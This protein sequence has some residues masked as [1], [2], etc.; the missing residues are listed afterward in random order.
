MNKI[1]L[2][3]IVLFCAVACAPKEKEVIPEP[4]LTKVQL[5]T[6]YGDIILQLYNETPQHRDNFTKHVNNGVYDSVQYHRVIENFMIQAGNPAT[7]KET[8]DSLYLQQFEYFVPAEFAPNRF[9]KKGALAAARINH[10]DR[11]SSSTQFYIVQGKV[12]NDSLLINAEERINGWLAEYHVK[13][14]SI[15]KHRLDSLYIYLENDNYE[16]FNRINNE[17]RELAKTYDRF[18]KYTIPEDQRTVYK[19]LGGT[20]HLDQNYTVFGEVLKGLA[21]VD[22]IA[23]VN[24]NEYDRPLQSVVILNARIVED[25][26]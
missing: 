19:S 3:A 7:K 13:H 6:N 17:F 8:M 24:T 18:E 14:D 22:S 9:H 21:V 5:T 15:Y 23:A 10:P 20:P 2:L 26:K 25:D 11:A 12:F 16:A 1:S 4:P